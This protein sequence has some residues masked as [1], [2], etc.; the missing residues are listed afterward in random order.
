MQQTKFVELFVVLVMLALVRSVI[1]PI[2]SAP[3]STISK[4]RSRALALRPLTESEDP[5][6]ASDAQKI[7]LYVA[8]MLLAKGVLGN[9]LIAVADRPVTANNFPSFKDSTG[10]NIKDSGYNSTSFDASG[11]AAAAIVTS[12]AYTDAAIAAILAT[13]AGSYQRSERRVQAAETRTVV[14]WTSDY[15]SG[16]MEVFAGGTLVIEANG[17]LELG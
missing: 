4:G 8:N 14:A 13:L 5:S 1:L 9:V 2:V 16:G 11:A 3:L 10:L 17:V 7:A 12:E 6:K 15:I